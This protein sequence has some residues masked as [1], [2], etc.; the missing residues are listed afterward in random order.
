MMPARIYVAS[1]V[2]H[3]R[4]WQQQALFAPI[5][6]SWIN[7]AEAGQTE[8]FA[9]LWDTQIVNEIRSAT[10]L[11]LY[12]EPLDLPLRG[13]FVEVGMALACGLP[14][15]VCAPDVVVEGR[16]ARPLGSWV[17]SQLVVREDVL[18]RALGIAMSGR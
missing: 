13:P 12:V 15:I 8:D 4:M 17:H 2:H 5:I 14:V 3:W 18:G 6:S 1:R 16:T 10:C 7:E 9:A 11:L